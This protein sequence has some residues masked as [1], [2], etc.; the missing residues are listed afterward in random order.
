VNKILSLIQKWGIRFEKD[1][2]MLPLFSEVYKA[3]KGKGIPFAN[4][5]S[6]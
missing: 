4:P 6:V 5:E 2:E 3:L 1:H